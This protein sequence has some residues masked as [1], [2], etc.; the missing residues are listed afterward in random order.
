ME[1]RV[2]SVGALGGGAGALVMGLFAMIAAATYQHTGFFTPLYHIAS[3][4]IGTET[5]MRS[6]G[7]TYFSAGPALLGLLVH[8]L[9]G[10]VFGVVFAF[11]ASRLGLLGVAAVPVGV[12]Y[13]LIVMLFMAYVGLPI[14]AALLRGGDMVS[15][16][17]SLV[18]WGTFTA[19]HALYGFVLGAA[20]AIW[21]VTV[22]AVRSTA[23]VRA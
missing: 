4:I 11:G 19:E 7:T 2:I 17:A 21:G 13:G 9:V 10:I 22:G 14:T 1:R 20:W 8:M 16:M 15:D 6:M 12:A 23:E 18:G 5:M 3:P